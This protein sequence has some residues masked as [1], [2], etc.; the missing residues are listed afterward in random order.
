MSNPV[1]YCSKHPKEKMTLLLN[2]YVCDICDPPGG[3]G[4]KKPIVLDPN[5][6]VVNWN[7]LPVVQ[8]TFS[9]TKTATH[10][11]TY[12]R[13]DSEGYLLCTTCGERATSASS[14]EAS[15]GVNYPHTWKH[16]GLKVGDKIVD[17]LQL[18]HYWK[19]DGGAWNSFVKTTI[20]TGM[21][22]TPT[23]TY[24]RNDSDGYLISPKT[25]KRANGACG[26]EAK[27]YDLGMI[28]II[29]SWSHGGLQVGDR[30]ESSYLGV[31]N[32][33]VND[34]EWDGSKW[35]SIPHYGQPQPQSQAPVPRND[36]H[37]YL[38]CRCGSRATGADAHYVYHTCD[39]LNS[40][41]TLH[42]GLQ[43]RDRVETSKCGYGVNY[44]DE[45]DG[46]RWVS[47]TPIVST[48]FYTATSGSWG[49]PP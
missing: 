34:E 36:L 21:G 4:A 42:G 18:N 45:W 44:D 35:N 6:V 7:F 22:A 38:M 41:R 11:T 10:V 29:E 5:T 2:Q 17:P 16:G 30:V 8:T 15:H 37:G 31:V 9:G 3:F 26:N 49:S 14:I 46:N 32:F 27:I 25:G 13:N 40:T 33:A 12:N 48:V 43:I 19:W 47:I 24:A 23:A 28:N 39:G 20:H 1:R